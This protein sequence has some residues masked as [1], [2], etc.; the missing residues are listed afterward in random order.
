MCRY[1]GLDR[2]ENPGAICT[3]RLLDGPHV[4]V[5][6]AG[7]FVPELNT[8]PEPQLNATM[9]AMTSSNFDARQTP[10]DLFDRLNAEFKFTLDAAASKENALCTE[11]FTV[12]EDALSRCWKGRVFCNPP[13]G[14]QKTGDFVRK[15]VAERDCAEVIVVLVPSRTDTRWF[16]DVVYQ[17]SGIEVRFIKGRLKSPGRKVSWPFASMLIEIG[18]AHV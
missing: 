6:D 3:N 14:R 11:F 4:W 12:E 8:D 1:C 16:H 13:Y 17:S 9:V 7:V 10:R 2:P 5:D 15:A 18:R